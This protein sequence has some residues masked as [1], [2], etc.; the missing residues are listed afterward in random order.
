[1]AIVGLLV[2]VVAEWRM[3]IGVGGVAAVLYERC[4]HR[5][6]CSVHSFRQHHLSHSSRSQPRHCTGDDTC[7]QSQSTFTHALPPVSADFYS[8]QS[9][10]NA[11]F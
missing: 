9:F 2:L 5:Q 1:M 7:T 4:Y 8:G 11:G 6:T 10:K 3:Y